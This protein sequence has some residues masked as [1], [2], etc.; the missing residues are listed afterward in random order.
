MDL[1]SFKIS[2]TQLDDDELMSLLGDIRTSRRPVTDLTTIKERAKPKTRTSG[3]GKAS[4]AS[5]KA[6]L[7]P[8]QLQML[9]KKLGEGA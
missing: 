6:S 3:G 9:I 7:T 5:L 2:I 4:L 8:E 1:A